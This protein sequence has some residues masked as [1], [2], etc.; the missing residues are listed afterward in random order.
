MNSY[1]VVP[2]RPIVA[3]VGDAPGYIQ[4][5]PSIVRSKRKHPTEEVYTDILIAFEWF[6]ERLFEGQLSFPVFTFSRKPRMLGAFVPYRFRRV[7]GESAHEIILNPHYLSLLGDYETLSTLAH[8]M[9]HL[10]REEYGIEATSGRYRSRGYHDEV[11]AECMDRIGLAPSDTGAPGG[12]RTGTSVS[13]YVIDGG[14]FDLAARELIADGFVIRWRDRTAELPEATGSAEGAAF[15][16]NP[17][18]SRAKD[19][20]KFSCVSCGLNAWAKPSAQLKCTPCDAP[21]GPF[22]PEGA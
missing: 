6:N 3:L 2:D 14:P 9:A 8:E 10:W 18:P 16:P 17:N 12:K 20:I 13:H 7:S 21:L 4:D 11:W 1:A 15:P 19:R 5:D 22:I